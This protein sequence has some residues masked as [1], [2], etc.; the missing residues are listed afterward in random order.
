K[1]TEKTVVRG[2]FGRT[3][4]NPTPRGYGQGFSFTTILVSSLDG[5]RTPVTDFSGLFPNGIITPPGS[6]RGLE[7]SLGSGISFSN[8]DF[9]IPYV[10]NFSFGFQ[11]QLGWRTVL[12]VSYVGSRAYK[13]QSSYGGFNEPGADVR[14]LCDVTHGGDRNYC[15]QTLPNPFRNVSGFEGTG[16]FTGTTRSRYDL[17]RPY[18]Q[19]GRITQTE[20]N[21]GKGWYNAMQVI[22][23]RRLSNGFSIHG[24]YTFSKVMQLAGDTVTDDTNRLTRAESRG[25]ASEDRPHR[26]TFAGIYHLP[27]GRGKRFFGQMPGVLNA[28][29]GGWEAA[30]A[31]IRESGRP[32]D[33]PDPDD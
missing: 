3:Y 18:P 2:G 11:R 22:I 16:F 28:V 12:E 17:L 10:H 26:F 29:F 20:R 33:F 13:L 30:G 23:N 1:L 7:T 9:E 27:V 31:I 32:W 15:S 19:F 5:G 4:L 8:P 25:I 21:D 24:S 14:R 6:T